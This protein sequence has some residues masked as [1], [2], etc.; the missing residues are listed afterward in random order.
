MSLRP[1]H[2]RSRGTGTTRKRACRGGSGRGSRGLRA[3][4]F[5]RPR[6]N[7]FGD[8]DLQTAIS[9]QQRLKDRAQKTEDDSVFEKTEELVAA[10]RQRGE[11]PAK[12]K[13]QF[14]DDLL[15]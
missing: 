1:D 9:E 15:A 13:P 6:R 11:L 7:K 10:A 4:G 14:V 2:R 3:I 12:I 5:Y 8:D